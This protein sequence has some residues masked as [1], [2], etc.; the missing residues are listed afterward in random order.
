MLNRAEQSKTEH[1]RV[2]IN[3]QR[4]Y[5]INKLRIKV[6]MHDEV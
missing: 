5:K 1:Y 4:K 3:K 2:N 6:W